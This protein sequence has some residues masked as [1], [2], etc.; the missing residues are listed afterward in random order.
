MAQKILISYY[1]LTGN[2][3]K[4]AEAIQNATD[5]DIFAI[6]MESPYPKVYSEV[7]KASRPDWENNVKPPLKS[8][9]ANMD[10]YQVVF[11]GSPNWFGTMTPPVFSF[12]SEYDFAG[13]IV[14]PFLTHGGGGVSR[15]FKEAA[16]AVP[17]SNVLGGLAI[18]HRELDHIEE[19]IAEWLT[20]IELHTL[21]NEG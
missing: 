4:F 17:D 1:S 14:I 20:K 10:E 19:K 5:G 21:M 16:E 12:L 13:K 3:K 15:S 18:S 7:L 9:V 8:K 2:T 11:I 6:E